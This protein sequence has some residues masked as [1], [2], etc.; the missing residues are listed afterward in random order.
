M[1]KRDSFSRRE[2]R[3]S[4]IVGMVVAGLI[5]IAGGIL[6]L[7]T[8]VKWTAE[9][10]VVVLP[11]ADLDA[12]DSAAYYETLSRG[13]II[14]TFAEVA[15]NL[16]FE[17]QAEESL[18]LDDAQR[19]AVSTKVSVVPDTSVI[20][21]QATAETAAVAEQVADQTTTL[22]SGYL[23]GLS[24][25]Y[26]TDVVHSAQGSGYFS[27]TSPAVLFL[28]GIIVA[29]IAGLASQQAVYHLMTALH[30]P[31]P[32]ILREKV[33]TNGTDV[34]LAPPPRQPRHSARSRLTVGGG[35]R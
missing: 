15:D 5:V 10:V 23:A 14:A 1:I 35:L 13:Q 20:L 33:G 32:P 16:R 12:A 3:I 29:L 25:P 8:K 9:A 30:R 17:Q 11:A 7:N 24:K 27:G 18:G 6:A 21:I 19:A 34:D 31:K 22:A 28:L 26:R 4:I 2:V